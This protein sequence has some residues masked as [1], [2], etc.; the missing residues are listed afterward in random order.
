MATVLVPLAQGVEELEAVTV[1]DLLRRAGIEVVT[2]GLDTAPVKGSRGTVLLPDTTLDQALAREY[3]MLVLP[4]GQPGATHLEQDT[5]ILAL[6]GKMARDKRFTA[7]ICAAPRV[8]A[9]AGV[10]EGKRA[11]SFPGTLDPAQ[12]PNVRLENSAVVTDGRVI[13]SRGPGT[14][15][16][17][18]LE[19]IAL[20]AGKEKRDQVEAGLQR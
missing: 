12:W 5:R 15:M 19:L 6:A 20:L 14:A 8:L 10:L 4:G 3:D 13:T 7:A 17:F 9:R 16:D 11:T 2:A 18:A 1:V